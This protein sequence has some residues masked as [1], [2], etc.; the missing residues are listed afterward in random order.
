[1]PSQRMPIY[2][3]DIG[4][5]DNFYGFPFQEGNCFGDGV[6]V[7]MHLRRESHLDAYT[8]TPETVDRTIHD[9]EVGAMQ[10]ILRGRI[11]SLAGQLVHGETCM[12]TVT[13]DEHL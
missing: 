7:A 6:K 2:L 12:Y 3:W 4:G 13:P 10:D 11:P 1:M 8:C 9:E 5:G